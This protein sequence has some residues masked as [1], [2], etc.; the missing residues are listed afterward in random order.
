MKVIDYK[1]EYIHFYN[2]PFFRKDHKTFQPARPRA[3]VQQVHR[4]L[5]AT[6]AC[7][8]VQALLVSQGRRVMLAHCLLRRTVGG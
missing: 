1:K 5:Q 4:V 2:E 3:C 6:Q 8:V 7:Q